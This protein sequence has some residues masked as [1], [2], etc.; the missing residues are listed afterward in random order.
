[1]QRL[2]LL[3]QTSGREVISP[4]SRNYRD[5]EDLHNVYEEPDQNNEHYVHTPI[6][7][8]ELNGAIAAFNSKKSSVGL[9]ILSNEVLKDLPK[10][11]LILL[12]EICFYKC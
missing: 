11:V 8:L 4:K 12:H 2:K 7:R 10:N 1:M 6:T 9:D 3:V 5:N